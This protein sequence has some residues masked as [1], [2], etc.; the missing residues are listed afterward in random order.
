[1]K[2][3]FLKSSIVTVT[4]QNTFIVLKALEDLIC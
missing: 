2:I 1:M 3:L 4:F